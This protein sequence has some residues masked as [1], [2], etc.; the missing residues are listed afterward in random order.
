LSY[1]DMDT[2]A[3]FS[4]E[5]LCSVG[6]RMRDPLAGKS[7][8]RYVLE[9]Y[10][11]QKVQGKGY[12]DFDE[13]DA[14]ITG[15]VARACGSA[16]A[17]VLGNM[18]NRRCSEFASAVLSTNSLQ[19]FAIH[20]Q[21]ALC[22]LFNC[23]ECVLFWV[24]DEHNQLWRYLTEEE[25]KRNER[26][27]NLMQKE[28]IT[29]DT[30]CLATEAFK[31]VDMSGTGAQ[32]VLNVPNAQRHPKFNS[33]VD[34]KY[35]H[36]GML[37]DKKAHPDAAS[38]TR[39]VLSVPIA[40]TQEK[41]I[42]VVQLRNKLTDPVVKTEFNKSGVFRTDDAT[43]LQHFALQAS[44]VFEHALAEEEGREAV[45]NLEQSEYCAKSLMKI[46][47]TLAK[48]DVK[49]DDL[50]PLVVSESVKLIQCDRATLFLVHE[51]TGSDRMLWSKIAT[52]C[53]PIMVPLKETSIA[54]ATVCKGIVTNIAD[55]YRDIRF[56]PQWDRKSGYRTRSILCVPIIDELRGGKCIGCLQLINK[57]DRYD[58]LGTVIFNKRDVELATNLASVVSIA[59]KCTDQEQQAN[60][61]LD[62]AVGICATRRDG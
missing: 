22:R 33:D 8:P 53:P 34:E 35:I 4:C 17:W 1:L 40:N 13:T 10:N 3:K 39:C 48:G 18:Q 14:Y 45:L 27:K 46:S 16:I 37:Y 26:M 7:R 19:E 9:V 24:D 44:S 36:R 11:K 62:L 50:F 20:S 23:E 56:D 25:T 29:S 58:R 30:L 55:A 15:C 49:L 5:G 31:K 43:F 2:R 21:E 42:C 6:V 41:T 54:G 60:A 59:V 12:K 51:P 38:L 61:S 52:G 32:Y 28:F 47:Q 57:R